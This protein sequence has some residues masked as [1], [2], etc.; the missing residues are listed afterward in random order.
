MPITSDLTPRP[1]FNADEN[2]AHLT[3]ALAP[4]GFE[5]KVRGLSSNGKRNPSPRQ[6]TPGYS[7]SSPRREHLKS[8]KER[9]G[10][11]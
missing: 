5:P 10:S 11:R 1:D 9:Q 2:L 3:E 6:T 4:F 7:F 8:L